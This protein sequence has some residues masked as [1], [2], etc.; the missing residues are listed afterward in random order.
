MAFRW[1]GLLALMLWP[2][3]ATAREQSNTFFFGNSLTYHLEEGVAHTNTP[4]WLAQLAQA[5]GRDFAMDGRWGWPRQFPQDLPPEP[6]WTID[7]VANHWAPQETDFG[8]AGFDAVVLVL[9]NF[10][11]YQLPD[12]AYFPY[13]FQGPNPEGDSPLSVT[14]DLFDWVHQASPDSRLFLY[15]G[16]ADMKSITGRFPPWE[17]GFERYH[18]QNGGAYHAWFGD[19][20]DKIART[21]PDLEV[22]LIPVA[23]VFAALM[24]RGGLLEDVPPEELFLDNAPHGTP[25]AYFLAALVTYT[26][27]YEAAPPLDYRLPAEIHPEIR[28]KYAQI[29][30]TITQIMPQMIRAEV[31]PNAAPDTG[32]DAGPEVETASA[33]TTS[34]QAAVVTAQEPEPEAVQAPVQ[35]A[36][37]PA[38]EVPQPLPA[39]EVLMLPPGGVRPDG[40]PALA[41]GLGGI[42]DWSTQVPFLDLMKSAR[43]FTGHLPGQWGGIPPEE[44][45]AQGYVDAHGWPLAVPP[46][47]E[48]LVSVLLTDMPDAAV[49]L[50]GSYVMLYDGQAEFRLEGRAR[51]VHYE[52][53]RVSFF[54]EPGEGLVGLRITQISAEDPIRNIRI[55]RRDHLPLYEAGAVFNPDWLARIDD[56]RAVR[57]MNWMQTNGSTVTGWEDRPSLDDATWAAR[58]VPLPIM[59]RLVNRIG[60]DPW[61]TMPHQADDA[62]MRAFAQ[63]VRDGLR[64]DLKAYVEYSNEVWNFI[65]PQAEWAGQQAEAL[66]GPSPSGWMQF[67]GMRAAQVMQIWSDVFGDSAPERLVRVVATHTGWPGLEAD[68]LT[69]PLAYLALG[70]LPQDSFDAYAVTGYF[71]YELGGPEMA[72]QVDGWLDRSEAQAQTLAE[73][74]GLRH[75][76]LREYVAEHRFDG[77]IAAAAQSLESGSLRQLTQEIFPYHAQAAKAAGLALVMYEGGTHIVGHGERVNDARLTEFFTRLNYTP[78]M[79]KLYEA[80]LAGWDAAGGRLFNAFVDVGPP[81]QWGSWGALRHLDDRNPRWDMLMAYNATGPNDWEDRRAE[82]FAKGITRKANDSGQRLQGSDQADVLIGGAGPDVLISGGGADLLNGQG[83]DD[84]ALLPGVLA[85]YDLMRDGG[86]LRLTGPLADVQMIG[87]ETLTFEG[88]P[89]EVVPVSGL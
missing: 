29:V 83:G 45:R 67:Y 35:E 48:A 58:G 56:L 9:E 73:A 38:Q 37:Q 59:L 34:A 76:A 89:G 40:V 51:R 86:R 33:D 13:E 18:V 70:A 30:R 14:L 52:P 77:A 42:A 20:L 15:E 6:G 23:E 4:Y 43:P 44:L 1:I 71:G 88:T 57:F 36:L 16:W 87:I 50:R 62:Y 28:A 68:V 46:E 31:A 25:S 54:Y 64:P 7:G 12:V 82:D 78:E 47:A 8:A 22:E 24:R 80:L 32:P 53:G 79:A 41:M 26:A 65:F 11:Q 19:L 85:D 55:L 49:S 60:A 74:Q 17:R 2:L 61:F 10:V 66:W 3:M 21:R 72:A 39:R 69:A 84:S 27:L 63:E 75:V 5:S 81:S